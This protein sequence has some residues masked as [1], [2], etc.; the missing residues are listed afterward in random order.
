M[1]T[2][3]SFA[4]C[5]L[6]F[7]TPELS[8]QP[9]PAAELQRLFDEMWVFEMEEYP[10]FATRC[11]VYDYNDRLP[12][13]S[14]ESEK[15]RAAFWSSLLYRLTK[16]SREALP[17]ADKVSYD[18]FQFVLQDRIAQVNFG[19]YCLPLNAEGGFHTDFAFAMRNMPLDEVA[20]YDNYILR[21]RAFDEYT[22]AHI[23]LMGEG[24]KREIT[25]PRL[26]TEK[27]L[28]TVAPFLID[29]PLESE[30]YAPFAELPAT[31]DSTTQAELRGAAERA[32]R[33]SVLPA[34]RRLYDFIEN[35][36]LPKARTTIAASE[37]P[38]GRQYYEQRIRY[39]TTLDMTPDEVFE[40][41]QAEVARIREE[42]E[43][44]IAELNYEG[45]F[46]SFLEFLRTDP[47]FYAKTS[48]ELLHYAAWLSKTID[49]MLPRYFNR[50]PR[51]PYGVAPV[52]DDIAPN[53]TGGRYVPG[54]LANHRAGTYWVNTY[55]LDS[56]PL[57]VLPALTLH[58]AVP[59]HHLQFALSQEL[60]G[61]PEFR[62]NLYL[63]AF[64][65]GWAL[66]CEYLG[67][68]MG[69]Y[70]TP[71]DHFGRLTYEMWRACRLVIDVGIHYKGWTREQAVGYLARH[72]ALSLHEVNTEID[73]YIGWPGQA[74]S[75]KIG[76]LKIRELR[77]RA[78][79]AAGARFDLREFHDMV[80]ANG[81][82][83]LSTLE[84]IVRDKWK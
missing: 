9:S 6:L 83:P 75:Y 18:V 35:Q 40:K 47:R 65:E 28:A 37:L 67:Q 69:L 64:G 13:V 36:Y 1:R 44:V 12:E 33:N 56:R 2:L 39:F 38:S 15:R 57:Y 42:M 50:L 52:P 30:F 19:A 21:L 82:I 11:G 41:G 5:F 80:L 66:Y 10:L 45:S 43:A 54:A 31:I 34:Y 72:T 55:Q 62:Q 7:P 14:A 4:A 78:E 24:I 73:R 3:L 58:E 68:E 61:V 79:A 22:D 76:E 26:I 16:L 48:E 53:Y 46:E 49:G 74:V 77:E 20:H 60:D 70:R 17:P 84:E 25:Q 23:A 29:N 8:A 59:G 63:S 27:A 71:Y 32:I 51:L 81:S